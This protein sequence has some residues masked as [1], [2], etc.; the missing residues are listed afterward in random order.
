MLNIRELCN[1]N[2]YELVFSRFGPAAYCM[3]QKAN[4]SCLH[5]PH[6]VNIYMQTTLEFY[7]YR[8]P[9]GDIMTHVIQ[10][11][12]DYVSIHFLTNIFNIL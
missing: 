1:Y 11:L 5:R 2:Q 6:P 9:G 3:A 12:I 10:Y 7:Q 8:H 4:M